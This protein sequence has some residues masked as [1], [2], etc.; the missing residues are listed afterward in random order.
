MCCQCGISILMSAILAREGRS[1]EAT[2]QAPEGF[3]TMAQAQNALGV[4]KATLQRLVRDT[5]FTV[6]RDYRDRRVRLLRVE[7]VARLK[8]PI[9]E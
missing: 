9:P 6:Y 8:T 3:L 5:R 7:D 4:S 1:M 2:Y